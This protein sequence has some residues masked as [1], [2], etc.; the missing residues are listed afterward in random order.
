MYYDC[1]HGVRELCPLVAGQPVLM[2]LDSDSTWTTSGTI[3]R[4]NPEDRTYLV[5]MPKGVVRR[6]RRHLQLVPAMPP[7][8]PDEIEE[9]P[10]QPEQ[11][12]IPNMAMSEIAP[13]P[14]PAATPP[15]QGRPQRITKRPDCL[16]EKC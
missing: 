10:D 13:R 16:I 12:A 3:V 8:P 6:N 5:Q 11:V 9:E 1:C 2:K 14:G 4:A 7:Q 15:T